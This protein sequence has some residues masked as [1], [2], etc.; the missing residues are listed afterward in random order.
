M[1]GDEAGLVVA[2]LD[3]QLPAR[4]AVVLRRLVQLVLDEY[5]ST[6]AD[7]LRALGEDDQA[8]W[9]GAESPGSGEQAP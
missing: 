2:W 9:A 3:R 5:G 8:P 1:E 6:G 4:R 7:L